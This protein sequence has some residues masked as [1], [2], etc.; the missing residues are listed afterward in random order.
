MRRRQAGILLHISSLPSN[1]GIGDLG[2]SAYEFVKLLSESKHSLWQILPIHP[3]LYKHDNSPYYSTSL[4]A[5]NYLLISPELLF[6]D[7]LIKKQTLEG[8]RLTS[9]SK[10]P[11]EALYSLKKRALEEAFREFSPTKDFYDFCEQNHYWLDSYA[12]FSALLTKNPSAKLFELWQDSPDKEA[13]NFYYFEQ[14]IFQKQFKALKEFANKLGV[15]L[16][17][18]MPIYPAPISADTF[19]RPELFQLS[20]E[21]EPEFVAGVPPDYFSPSGQLWGNPVYNW[22]SHKAEGFSWWILRLRRALELFDLIRIDHFRG[23]CAFYKTRG[24]PSIGEW[25]DA[26]GEDLFSTLRSTFPNA[27]LIAEDLG[28]IDQRVNSLRERFG[29]YSTRVLAFGLLDKD[30]IHLPHNH[31]LKCAVYTTTHD[32]PPLKSFI[33]TLNPASRDFFLSY[34]GSLEG[35]IRFAYASVSELCI[36][37]MQDILMLDESCRYNTPAT[38]FGNWRWKLE[39]LPNIKDYLKELSQTFSRS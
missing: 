20:K 14:Y 13:V 3:T 28:I 21:G 16:I 38:T 2:Q 7:G 33:N 12:R 10:V 18:D 8:L 25:E 29:L 27:K 23:F 32:L 26:P 11:F 22:Q 30:S 15:F 9:Y 6:Q 34:F 36:V 35:L 1:F 37:P 24:E 5:G 39:E 31:S 4:F 19:Q 17:G